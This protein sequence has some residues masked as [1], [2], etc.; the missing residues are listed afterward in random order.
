M[1][2]ELLKDSLLQ[3]KKNLKNCYAPY[4]KFK[5]SSA[6]VLKYKD[7]HKIIKGVNIE[8][9]SYGGS[10]CAERNALT[11]AVSNGL[12]IENEKILK[13]DILFMIITYDY[14]EDKKDKAEIKLVPCGICLQFISE[15]CSID[16]PIYI[17]NRNTD[18]IK[19][20]EKY[21]LRDFLPNPFNHF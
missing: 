20:L 5:V 8:N 15:L 14:Y 6:V 3:I 21:T 19:D 2:E 4:S 13:D 7:T 11:Q 9:I 16:L 17:A 10:I 12:L 18:N 1:K